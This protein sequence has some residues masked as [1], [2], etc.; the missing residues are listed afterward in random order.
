VLRGGWD[1]LK[2]RAALTGGREGEAEG[3]AKEKAEGAEDDKDGRQP[4]QRQAVGTGK[5]GA[6][7]GREG[8]ASDQPTA[9]RRRHAYIQIEADLSGGL[10]S[11]WACKEVSTAKAIF[12]RANSNRFAKGDRHMPERRKEGKILW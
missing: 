12:S 10:V 4:R 11:A 7:R 8:W 9:E 3:A 2:R 5:G 6:G 1:G